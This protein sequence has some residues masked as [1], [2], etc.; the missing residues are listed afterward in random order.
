[1]TASKE[2]PELSGSSKIID[3]AL[4]PRRPNLVPIRSYSSSAFPRFAKVFE[5]SFATPK[6]FVRRSVKSIEDREFADSHAW[7]NEG[8]ALNC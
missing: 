2:A 4:A 3:F 1:M 8:G 6:R 7:E 5:D